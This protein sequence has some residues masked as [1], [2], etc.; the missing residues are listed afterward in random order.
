MER[1]E[2]RWSKDTAVQ[3][4]G[5]ATGRKSAC[6]RRRH[7]RRRLDSQVGEMPWSRKR[8]PTPTFSPGSF[9]GQ[10][11]HDCSPCGHKELDMTDWTHTHSECT[12]KSCRKLE[13]GSVPVDWSPE[14]LT[15]QWL[16]QRPKWGAEVQQTKTVCVCACVRACVCV[17]VC[18]WL[19]L[20]EPGGGWLKLKLEEGVFG[21]QAH[22][23]TRLCVWSLFQEQSEDKLL[24]YMGS[25]IWPNLHFKVI[26]C[27]TIKLKKKCWI[28]FRFFKK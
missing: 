23:W 11:N 4:P 22:P 10:R 13:T 1:K 7:E 26:N 24:K 8:H 14:R 6:Q 3:F 16:E 12:V 27:Q 9:H 15:E 5:G 17:C 19:G 2:A 18:V 21:D 25:G 20:Q 28:S